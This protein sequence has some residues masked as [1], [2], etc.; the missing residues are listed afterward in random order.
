ME[1]MAP[2]RSSNNGRGEFLV[3]SGASATVVGGD[4]FIC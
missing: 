2:I 3:D 4:D 1:P